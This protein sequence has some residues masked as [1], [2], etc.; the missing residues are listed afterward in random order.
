MAL[1]RE[2]KKYIADLLK[3]SLRSVEQRLSGLEEG[4]ATVQSHV[5]EIKENMVTKG[6][7][8]W[9]ADKIIEGMRE[10][11][12][13]HYGKIIELEERVGELEEEVREIK[14]QLST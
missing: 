5:A 12:D 1:T 14:R 10:Q 7:M 3:E 8:R 9:L 2:D 11:G 13:R 4:Q 6:D